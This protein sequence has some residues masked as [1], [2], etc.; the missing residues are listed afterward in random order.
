MKFC[1]PPWEGCGDKKPLATLLTQIDEKC[2]AEDF[3]RHDLVRV[4]K[5]SIDERLR[6]MLKEEI[7]TGQ[8][9]VEFKAAKADNDRYGIILA[10]LYQIMTTDGKGTNDGSKAKYDL[11]EVKQRDKTLKDYTKEFERRVN[12][13]GL[14]GAILNPEDLRDLAPTKHGRADI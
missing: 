7:T 5:N 4:I 8:M 12:I 13:C 10:A 2:D 1:E 9:A 6:M 11:Y 14:T 3:T